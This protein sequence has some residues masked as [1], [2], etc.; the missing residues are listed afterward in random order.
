MQVL[1]TSGGTKIPIDLVRHI[2]NMSRGT[3]GAQIALAGLKAKW[4]VN[5]LHAE[6]SRTP[7]K[8]ELDFA[9][10]GI[11]SLREK[12]S[13]FEERQTFLPQYQESVYSDFNSYEKQLFQ[14]IE[15]QRPDVIILAAAVSDYGTK[16]VLGKIRSGDA[17][18][19]PLVPLP[20]LISRV[21]SAAPLA[22]LVGFKLL[23]NSTE[24]ELIAAAHRSVLTNRCDLVVAND[25][26]DIKNNAHRLLLVRDK[27]GKPVVEECKEN[28]A[29]F[30]VQKIN[31]IHE[32]LI[33]RNR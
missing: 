12:F 21:R 22:T 9:K 4:K 1:L 30:L 2:A 29:N 31:L 15:V 19:I 6:G 18:N 13:A 33:G 11:G 25:L 17:M 27:D 20:K 28:L 26:R 10:T 3:F 32:D 24:E 16:P 14:Q 7:F 23:V 5:F 8:C